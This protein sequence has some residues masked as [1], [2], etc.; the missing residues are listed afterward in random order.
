MSTGLPKLAVWGRNG[1]SR[2]TVSGDSRGRSSPSRPQWSAAAAPGPPE[3]VWTTNKDGLSG[4][5]HESQLSIKG[6]TAHATEDS[7]AQEISLRKGDVVDS[8][9]ELGGWHWC[10]KADGQEGWTPGYNLRASAPD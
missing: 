4:W 5:V 8:L 2:S 7:N 9:R 6:K 1:F 3:W 10:R